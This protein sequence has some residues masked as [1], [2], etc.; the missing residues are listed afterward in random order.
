[1]NVVMKFFLTLLCFTSLIYAIDKE[2]ALKEG[3][4]QI[5]VPYDNIKMDLLIGNPELEVIW[6]YQNGQYNL[7]TNNLRYRLLE[8]K[9]TDIGS[10]E[11][12]SIGESIYVLAK[13][14][15]Y[16][17]FVGVEN[18]NP[19]I[20]SSHINSQWR[21]MS[22]K[23]FPSTEWNVISK[24]VDGAPIIASKIVMEDSKPSLKVYTN[25]PNEVSKINP[26]YFQDFEVLEN[27]SFWI[28]DVMNVS[29]IDS[30]E[31]LITKLPSQGGEA[32]TFSLEGSSTNKKRNFLPVKIVAIKEGVTNAREYVLFDDYVRLN[33]GEQEIQAIIPTLENEDS[34]TY[35]IYVIKDLAAQYEKLGID[36]FNLGD[37]S[38]EEILQADKE[39]LA[40]SEY[41]VVSLSGNASEVTYDM[42]IASREYA[43]S[44]L[45]YDP[46]KELQRL[47]KN[48]SKDLSAYSYE[49]IARHTEFQISL[50]A[51]GNNSQKVDLTKVKAYL[52]VANQE[53]ELIVLRKNNTLGSSYDIEDIQIS[54][55]QEENEVDLTLSLMMY[56]PDAITNV[57]NKAFYTSVLDELRETSGS[58]EGRDLE[59]T[60]KV[61]LD[62]SC[63]QWIFK[64][65]FTLSFAVSSEE[66]SE[67]DIIATTVITLYSE[68]F[69][70]KLIDNYESKD[71]SLTLMNLMLSE[72]VYSDE[73][74]YKRVG[75]FDDKTD[76]L[77]KDLE[78]LQTALQ[79]GTDA[80]LIVDPLATLETK[81]VEQ[82]IEVDGG[83]ETLWNNYLAAGADGNTCDRLNYF[84]K[85][86][87]YIKYVHDPSGGD[88]IKVITATDDLCIYNVKY[89]Y[90][91]TLNGATIKSIALAYK[92]FILLKNTKNEEDRLADFWNPLFSLDNSTIHMPEYF[93]KKLPV[94]NRSI[95]GGAT[96]SS[97][98]A[99]DSEL[100]ELRVN[101]YMDVDIEL[102][103]GQFKLMDLDYETVLSGSDSEASRFNL[104]IYSINPL[105]KEEAFTLKKIFAFNQA[106]P[107][108]YAVQEKIDVT[109]AKSFEFEF[110]GGP[111]EVRFLFEMGVYNYFAVGLD[112][113]MTNQVILYAVPG[114]R[115]YGNI[116]GGLSFTAAVV[117][118]D[119]AMNADDFTVVRAAVPI[120]AKL[121]SFRLDREG[122]A[123]TFKLFSNVEIKAAEILIELFIDISVGVAGVDK[124]VAS[125]DATL[126]D[127]SEGFDVLEQLGFNVG[128]GTAEDITECQEGYV[129]WELFCVKK[130][131]K[132]KFAFSGLSTSECN[133][134]ESEYLRRKN[135]E[136][137]TSY[138]Y[139]TNE[140]RKVRGCVNDSYEFIE[141]SLDD[142]VLSDSQ[143]DEVNNIDFWRWDSRA[144]ISQ[145]LEEEGE[146]LTIP[147]WEESVFPGEDSFDPVNDA[148]K[149]LT[150]IDN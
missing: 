45:Y 62:N 23:D 107:T 115:I 66:T 144:L 106:I 88:D 33:N 17:T 30:F 116:S 63:S 108:Q 40:N 80:K 38:A 20:R 136:S 129:G 25:D 44:V 77:F 12:L 104:N 109:L 125:L 11:S 28:R 81:L 35:R 41:R 29:D 10:L 89:D 87:P 95:G 73:L 7:L 135:F 84:D 97:K 91:K 26:E 50:K 21:Q 148:W 5:S 96:F 142:W 15:T 94:V 105:D 100:N 60:N 138:L 43:N 124:S 69:D 143:F 8:K 85:T 120:V 70:N 4:N 92:N 76:Q 102:L 139:S 32:I 146:L 2:I 68:T 18:L 6:A 67:D 53:K 9:T 34:G 99:L 79:T 31:F 123:T 114:S 150:G 131:L 90:L 141:I 37:E 149:E 82:I 126:W 65:D 83:L 103:F 121:D 61:C 133:L 14:D 140:Y 56:S 117:R 1:M 24:I 48:Q 78:S 132:V 134:L 98:L 130:E 119:V 52:N 36:I 122:F 72:D 127:N 3:W 147:P 19:P 42:K 113:D 54:K 93:G 86:L 75:G 59:F 110:G 137:D 101:A 39:V 57:Q 145:R 47:A 112:V 51:Y 64:K 118:L 46:Y 27:E 55:T 16:I 22:R 58:T 74:N 49:D 128:K 71:T 111:V 13:S